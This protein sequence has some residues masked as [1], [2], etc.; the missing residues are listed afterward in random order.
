MYY[1][2]IL[3]NC[4]RISLVPR[5]KKRKETIKKELPWPITDLM[6]GMA[7]CSASLTA[8]LAV[9]ETE[10]E[11]NCHTNTDVV[12]GCGL[13][14]WSKEICLAYGLLAYWRSRKPWWLSVNLESRNRQKPF[15]L[16]SR[17]CFQC[18]NSKKFWLSSH[19]LPPPVLNSE[20]LPIQAFSRLI[21]VMV[22][23]TPII[24]LPAGSPPTVVFAFPSEGDTWKKELLKML[25]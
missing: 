3:P 25:S 1:Y 5:K 22:P 2:H 20:I 9:A 24:I 10:W 4:K 6:V 14:A 21:Y 8:F 17:F 23:C 7:I 18:P 13:P 15:S 19:T 16:G 11:Q 12:Q